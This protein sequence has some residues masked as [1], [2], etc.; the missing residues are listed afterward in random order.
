MH[1]AYFNI[2]SPYR[3]CL[4]GSVGKLNLDVYLD[5]EAKEIWGQ[6]EIEFEFLSFFSGLMMM[7]HDLLLRYEAGSGATALVG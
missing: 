1:I 3:F 6:W 2:A 4:L 5:T 7:W